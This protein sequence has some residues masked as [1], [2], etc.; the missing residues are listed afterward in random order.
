MRFPLVLV[1]YKTYPEALGAKGL[2][3][4]KLLHDAG[5]CFAVA[6]QLA[7]LRLVAGSVDIPVYA[8]HVD[9]VKP[10]SH[11]GHVLPE[12]VKDAG[13]TGTLL[14]HSE[15]RLTLDVLDETMGRA[16]GAGLEV[17]ACA[18]DAE[19]AT[20]IAGLDNKPDAIAVEPPELIGTGVSVS[21]AKPEVLASAVKKVHLPLLCGAGITTGEDVRKSL[22]LG[23]KGVLLASGVVK[24][25]DAN[26]VI[27][28]L[29][30]A[31][32]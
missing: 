9:P 13:C 12:D 7:D 25:K 3:L 27:K 24:T 26:A 8:Q 30:S 6:P 21:T 18:K 1:N 29:A 11:T 14:N 4:A 5:D 10:G 20:L 28:D 16:R 22:E 19:E 17:I 2:W 15:H 32:K 31:V 23:M